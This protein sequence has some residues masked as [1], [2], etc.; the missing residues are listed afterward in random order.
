M[1]PKK[2]AFTDLEMTGLDPLKH[3]I[4]EFGLVVADE[5]L[6]EILARYDQKVKPEHIETAQKEAL[7]V[8]GYK[9]EDWKDAILLKDALAKY[10]ELAEGALFAAWNTPFDWTFLSEAYRKTEMKNPFDYHTLDVFSI[11]HEKLRADTSVETFRLSRLCEHFGI[12]REPMPHRA[13]NGAER[14]HAL[15]KKLREL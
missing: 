15:Y 7:G 13:I 3:E 9:E 8:A 10:S 2:I 6:L 1:K 5:E 11:A 14:A 12:P 4:I